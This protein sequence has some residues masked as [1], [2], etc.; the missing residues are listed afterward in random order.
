MSK[1][2]RLQASEVIRQKI[3]EIDRFVKAREQQ[4][5][6]IRHSSKLLTLTDLREKQ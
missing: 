2:D 3:A 4:S 5:A 1:S 6:P